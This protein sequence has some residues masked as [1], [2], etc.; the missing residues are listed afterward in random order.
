MREP[1]TTSRTDWWPPGR[2]ASV[3]NEYAARVQECLSVVIPCYN[4]ESTIEA[5]LVAVLAQPTVAEVVVVDDGST[6][7]SAEIVDSCLDSRVRLIRQPRN[8]GKGAALRRG[9]AEA[10]QPYVIIQDADLEYDPREYEKL[11]QPLF[12]DKADVVY[13]SRFLSGE[14]RRVLYYWHS[15]GNRFLTLASNM[16]TNLNFTDMETCYKVF[17]REVIQSILIEEDR[18]GFEPEITAKIARAGWRVHEVG[19]SYDGR[20]YAEGKK[21]N[22]KDGL[23]ALW[24]IGRYGLT[25]SVPSTP[26]REPAR[27]AEADAELEG[28]LDSLGESAPNYAAWIASLMEPYLGRVVVEI[29]AGHGTMV[30]QLRDEGRTVVATDVSKRCLDVLHGR[31]DDMAGVEVRELD[32]LVDGAPENVDSVVLVNVLEHLDDLQALKSIRAML[33][34]GGHLLLF[35][36]ALDA[37]YSRFDRAV[38]HKRRYT[39]RSLAAR[40]RDAGFV[41]VEARYVNLP[42]ALAWFVVARLLRQ[43]P[44]ADALVSIFDRQVVPRLRRLEARIRPVVGQSVFLAA[45]VPGS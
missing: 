3:H 41:V 43:T 45:V 44:T 26:E 19:I 11:L 16:T 38:G 35:V 37:L 30:E 24:C 14:P 23:R 31:Y 40:V 20:T 8:L 34:V 22:W 17:R 28:V 6:D 27:F 36:P 5:I 7:A 33:P 25:M 32:L 9:M 13:G 4:E 12:E 39:K 42:G 21:I 18:F 1:A 2:R 10:S 15:V 29:G